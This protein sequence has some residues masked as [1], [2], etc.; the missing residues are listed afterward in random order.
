M[1]DQSLNENLAL[2]SQGLKLLNTKRNKR[3]NKYAT[4]FTFTDSVF[5]L[6]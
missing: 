6:L 4:D 5:Q 1:F 3:F 2:L